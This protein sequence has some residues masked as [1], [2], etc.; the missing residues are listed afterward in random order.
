MN[1]YYFYGF[2][3]TLILYSGRCPSSVAAVD[4][5]FYAPG[6]NYTHWFRAGTDLCSMAAEYYEF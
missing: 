6:S 1:E 2:V 4:H 3:M 5:N